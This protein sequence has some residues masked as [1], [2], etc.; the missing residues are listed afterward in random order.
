MFGEVITNYAPL[1]GAIKGERTMSDAILIKIEN[2]AKVAVLVGTAITTLIGL[3]LQ[4]IWVGDPIPIEIFWAIVL[5]AVFYFLLH[6]LTYLRFYLEKIVF[7]KE[8]KVQAEIKNQE[9]EIELR[10]L[11][12]QLEIKMLELAQVEA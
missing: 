9:I 7:L 3:M 11:E 12:V 6:L 4:K 2:W 8:Q 1:A 10:K 5:L